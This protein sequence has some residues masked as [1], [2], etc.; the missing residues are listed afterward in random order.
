MR[1]SLDVYMPTKN[2]PVY[3]FWREETQVAVGGKSDTKN[4]YFGHLEKSFQQLKRMTALSRLVLR[5]VNITASEH[6]LLLH[7]NGLQE[8]LN[9]GANVVKMYSGPLWTRMFNLVGERRR[10]DG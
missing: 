4:D 2:T 1:S 3:P 6:Q 7:A 9:A 8:M 10:G 5:D